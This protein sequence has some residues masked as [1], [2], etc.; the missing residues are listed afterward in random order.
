[1]NKEQKETL[2][3]VIER[4]QAATSYT[5]HDKYGYVPTAMDIDNREWSSFEDAMKGV[6]TTIG[7]KIALRM[8]KAPE[9]QDRDSFMDETLTS[10]TGFTQY[11]LL[12]QGTSTIVML[13]KSETEL[14]A[15]RLSGHPDSYL[16]HTA[17]RDDFNRSECQTLLQPIGRTIDLGENAMQAEILP[18]VQVLSDLA[19]EDRRA[20]HAFLD[21]LL[22]DTIY[23]PKVHEIAALPDGTV[24]A[25]DPGECMYSPEY[26]DLSEADQFKAEAESLKLIESRLKGWDI[27]PHLNPID[28]NGDLKQDR[29][30]PMLSMPT[31]IGHDQAPEADFDGYR[32]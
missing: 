19:Y 1:M 28:K 26:W 24:I 2:Q 8:V 10:A 21:E 27:S 31:H 16:G 14:A 6:K 4:V 7:N 13:A 17:Y 9:G 15:V 25:F 22:E 29:F 3:G 30:F 23:K 18:P 12:A 32:M 5:E 11:S 20:Y